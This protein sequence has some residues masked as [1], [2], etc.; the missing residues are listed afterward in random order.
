MES[1]ESAGWAPVVPAP[2]QAR[3]GLDPRLQA[4][5]HLAVRCQ[6]EAQHSHQVTRLA[7]RLFDELQPLHRL[8]VEERFWLECGALLHDIGWVEGQQKHHKTAL[9]IILS[10]PRLPFRTNER[11][12]I[13]AIARYHR[14]ALPSEKHDHFAALRPAERRVVRITAGILR[15]AD[16]LDRTHRSLVRDLTCRI[17]PGQIAIECAATEDA[18][19]ECETAADKGALLAQALERELVIGWHRV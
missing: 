4:V 18:Q 15:V 17:S 14:K 2:R 7:L 1:A 3:E 9:R 6:Y 12:I 19:V 13:G 5:L 10:T 8:G 16:G 11:F